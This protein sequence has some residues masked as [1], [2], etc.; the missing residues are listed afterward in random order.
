[1]KYMY[2]Y[3]KKFSFLFFFCIFQVFRW[4]GAL[5]NDVY[6]LMNKSSTARLI[7]HICQPIQE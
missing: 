2:M 3:K 6:D 1:M 4:S 5:I 7:F